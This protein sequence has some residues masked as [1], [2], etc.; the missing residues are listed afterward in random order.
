MVVMAEGFLQ[1]F[2]VKAL[3]DVL[4]HQPNIEVLSLYIREIRFIL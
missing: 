2:E 3:R 1:V 4:Y